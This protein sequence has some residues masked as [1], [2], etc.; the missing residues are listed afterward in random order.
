MNQFIKIENFNNYSISNL[1]EIRND[2]TMRIFK[3]RIDSA[4]YKKID[5]REDKKPKTFY[6]HRLIAQAFIANHNNLPCIDHCVGNKLNNSLENLRW[7]TE[8][9]NMH[10]RTINSNNTSGIKGV[11]YQNKTNKWRAT[12][13]LNNI[14]IHIGLFETKDEA[15]L[16]RKIKAKEL[17]GSF[18]NKIEVIRNELDELEAEFVA[19]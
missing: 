11:H 3:T 15:E 14:R 12:I 18:L 1:G 19:L 5:L 17:F 8:S 9:Q 6:I 13:M 2:K 4:G 10:N 7:C 16:A